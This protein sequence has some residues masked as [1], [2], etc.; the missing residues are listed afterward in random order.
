[1]EFFADL[2][3]ENL[4]PTDPIARARARFFIETATP[5]IMGAWYGSLTRGEDP[6]AVSKA[7][8]T[9]QNLL[10]AEGY[11]VG[12]WS[13]ADAAVTPF[14]ARAEITLKNDLGKYEEGKGKAVWEALENDPKYARFRKYFNDVKN[15]ASFKETFHP[16]RHLSIVFEFERH[17]NKVETGCGL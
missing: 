14:F 10:P 8:E 6:A 1:M 12:E 15:R 5:L 11:A 3:Q 13:I 4:L 16:V 2:S 9:I 17:A 7:V